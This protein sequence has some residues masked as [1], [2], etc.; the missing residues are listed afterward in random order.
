MIVIKAVFFHDFAFVP[1]DGFGGDFVE[2]GNFTDI[3]AMIMPVAT[4]PAIWTAFYAGSGCKLAW[5]DL[6]SRKKFTPF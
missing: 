5:S 1:G 3:K 2:S 6:A 4:A